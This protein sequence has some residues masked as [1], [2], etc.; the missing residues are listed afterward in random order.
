MYGYVVVSYYT[1]RVHLHIVCAVF[2]VDSF[3]LLVQRV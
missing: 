2:I 3:T 1:L